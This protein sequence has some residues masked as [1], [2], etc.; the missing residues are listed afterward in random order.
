M[1]ASRGTVASMSA[2]L[3]GAV[4]SQFTTRSTSFRT[5]HPLASCASRCR[6]P[7][8]RPRTRPTIAARSGSC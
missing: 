2:A 5:C 7:R 8:G 4:G 1:M 3:C 6:A